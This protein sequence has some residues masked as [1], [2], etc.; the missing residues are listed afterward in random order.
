[1]AAAAGRETRFWFERCGSGFTAPAWNEHGLD[2]VDGMESVSM[3]LTQR[4]LG[5][6][7]ARDAAV[8]SRGHGSGRFGDYVGDEHGL[9]MD[10]Q[11]WRE[12]DGSPRERRHRA[13]MIWF[14][15]VILAVDWLRMEEQ[16]GC[17]GL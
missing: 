11:V 6:A 4:W 3:G 8:Q 5:S 12:I 1:M 2:C 17:C 16:E 9:L 15:M 14:G 13:V 7:T 10:L